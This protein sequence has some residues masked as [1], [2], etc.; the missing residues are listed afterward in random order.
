[1]YVTYCILLFDYSHLCNSHGFQAYFMHDAILLIG[2]CILF[3]L[4]TQQ[5][6][7]YCWISNHVSDAV[8]NRGLK[9]INL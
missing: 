5:I 1:M 2:L 7:S 8:C 9:F 4:L 3:V 6:S